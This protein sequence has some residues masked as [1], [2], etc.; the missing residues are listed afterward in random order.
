MLFCNVTFC[1]IFSDKVYVTLCV[2]TIT[3]IIRYIDYY[4]NVHMFCSTVHVTVLF[5][6]IQ[7]NDPIPIVQI[8][9]YF[10]I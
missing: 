1:H 4:K 2:V 7:G 3:L 10:M 9:S 6:C 8:I 5:I